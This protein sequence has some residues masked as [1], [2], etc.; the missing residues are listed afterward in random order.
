MA[1]SLMHSIGSAINRFF[2]KHRVEKTRTELLALDDH[3][4]ADIGMTRSELE[5]R[6]DP[7]VL[8]DVYGAKHDPDTIRRPH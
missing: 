5:V 7:L 6:E 2:E 8:H 1:H 4:L 3:A